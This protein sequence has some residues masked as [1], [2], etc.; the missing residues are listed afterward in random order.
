MNP[1]FFIS[2]AKVQLSTDFTSFFF[3]YSLIRN[4][5]HKIFQRTLAFIHFPFPGA[6]SRAAASARSVRNLN[7]PIMRNQLKRF[8]RAI[9]PFLAHSG[10]NIAPNQSGVVDVALQRDVSVGRNRHVIDVNGQIF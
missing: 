8:V 7:L 2:L 3:D 4:F 9:R 6:G 10:R 5:P 1:G